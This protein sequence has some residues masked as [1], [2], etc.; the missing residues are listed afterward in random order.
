MLVDLPSLVQ[1]IREIALAAG[2]EIMA[3]YRAEFTVSEKEDRSPL[4]EADLVAHER[5][6]AELTALTPDIPVISE[7]A[8]TIP[9]SAR[10]HWEWLWLVDPLDGTRE[11]IKR[12]DEFSVNIALIHHHEPVLGLI[13]MPVT[14]VCYFAHRQSGAFKQPLDHA[15]AR[16]HTRRVNRAKVRVACSRAAYQGRR[17]QTYLQ[18]LGEHHHL[19]VGSALKSCLVAEGKADL[20]PRFGPTC[21]WDTA[22]AQ[23]IVEQ[24]GGR[25]TDMHMQPMQYNARPT[26]INPD[27]FAFG[28]LKH[29]WS[30]YLPDRKPGSALSDHALRTL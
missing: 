29:D 5:I 10:R 4:T 7:E 19:S 14:G 23:I 6:L 13:L 11:F 26:L 1:P 28:D 17:L 18:Y 20:Y 9:L 2:R 25:L 15:P 24:A 3:I 21:E 22:A 16:I 12:N 8:K 27:F 30:Q